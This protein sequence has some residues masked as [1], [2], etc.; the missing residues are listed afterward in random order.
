MKRKRQENPQKALSLE[1]ITTALLDLMQEKPYKEI[2]ITELSDKAN[3]SRRTFY[4]HFDSTDAVIDHHLKNLCDELLVLF[5]EIVKTQQR[6][7]AFV[8]EVFFAFWVKH[9]E[10]LAVLHDNDLAYQSLQ[11]FWSE[12]RTRLLGDNLSNYTL[13]Y[14]YYFTSGAMTNLLIKWIEEGAIRSPKEMGTIA[15]RVLEHLSS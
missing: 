2:A 7:F 4:R 1:G 13:D 9:K 10:F 8:V 12:V 6:D 15:S 14:M 11:K 5:E 3:L